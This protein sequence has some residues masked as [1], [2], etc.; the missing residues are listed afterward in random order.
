MTRFNTSNSTNTNTN[1]NT[2]MNMSATSKTG[3]AGTL[4]RFSRLAA[5]SAAFLALTAALAVTSNASGKEKEYKFCNDSSEDANDLHIKFNKGSLEVTGM[6]PKNAFPL[7]DADDSSSTV[8]FRKGLSGDGVDQGDCVI[9]KFKYS[10][11]DP[12]VKSAH[13]TKGNTLDPGKGDFIPDGGM[14][15]DDIICAWD[16]G[17]AAGDG[18]YLVMIDDQEREFIT[19]PGEPAEAVSARFAQFIEDQ[20]QFGSVLVEAP[21]LVQWTGNSYSPRRPN[22]W[23][24]VLRQDSAMPVFIDNCRM[25]LDVFNL[26]AGERAEFIV[27]DHHEGATVAIV[28]SLR[29]GQTEVNDVLGYCGSLGL[30][31]VTRQRLI[32]QGP[33]VGGQFATSLP[34]PPQAAG[35]ELHTQALLRN[36]CPT[37]CESNVWSGVIQK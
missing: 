4:G 18:A 33:I 17:E 37:S 24:E 6:T 29:P 15:A 10:G 32:G 36:T 16:G 21:G 22:A 35:L 31:G 30:A 34:I 19:L 25:Q 7:N 20:W 12:K 23:I 5:T 2:N 1:T 8:N 28:Y 9:I 11:T 14:E 26:V 27:T 3:A 13:W